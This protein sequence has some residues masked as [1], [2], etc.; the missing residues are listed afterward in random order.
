MLQLVMR[1]ER[2]TDKHLA[3]LLFSER[4]KDVGGGDKF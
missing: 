4:G 1:F 3:I 2:K